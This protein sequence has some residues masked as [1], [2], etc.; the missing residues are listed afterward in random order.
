VNLEWKAGPAAGARADRGDLSITAAGTGLPADVLDNHPADGGVI[1]A[2]AG[3]PGN[4]RADAG[5][6]AA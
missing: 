4:A 6:R 2:G 1:V 5:A 3:R